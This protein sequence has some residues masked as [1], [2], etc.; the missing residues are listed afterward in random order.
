MPPANVGGWLLK[1]HITQVLE[2]NA[3]VAQLD[4]ELK[5]LTLLLTKVVERMPAAESAPAAAPQK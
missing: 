3:N 1:P 4:Q 2:T 5:H